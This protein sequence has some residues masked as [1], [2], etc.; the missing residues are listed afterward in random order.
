[1]N[2]HS[3]FDAYDALPGGLQLIVAILGVGFVTVGALAGVW[4]WDYYTNPIFPLQGQIRRTSAS[5]VP[6]NRDGRARGDVSAHFDPA[7]WGDA[8]T[9]ERQKRLTA[10]QGGK[11]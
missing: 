3:L 9:S 6:E 4:T 10:L 5:G 1:M 8:Y 11:R 7:I 2:L